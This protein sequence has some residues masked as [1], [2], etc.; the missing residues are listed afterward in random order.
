[1]LSLTKKKYPKTVNK[2][3]TELTFLCLL[4]FT[5]I[6]LFNNTH[7]GKSIGERHTLRLFWPVEYR[8]APSLSGTI[9]HHQ[10][11]WPIRHALWQIFTLQKQTGIST[12]SC[13]FSTVHNRK[14]LKLIKCTSTTSRLQNIPAIRYKRELSWKERGISLCTHMWSSHMCMHL[15]LCINNVGL[16]TIHLHIHICLCINCF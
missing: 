13:L 3:Y 15:C 4:D 8:V 9:R 12:E 1:M 14:I 6:N 16:N 5:N 11:K 7:V 10:S 2:N